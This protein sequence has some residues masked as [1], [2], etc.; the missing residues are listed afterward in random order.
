MPAERFAIAQVTP[1][2]WESGHQVNVQ[3]ARS[4]ELLAERGHGV[5]IVAPSLSEELVRRSR[6]RIRAGDA[7]AEPGAVEVLAVGEVLPAP[8][9]ARRRA[10]LPI[11]VARSVE[12][13]VGGSSFDICHLHEPFAPSVASV[14]LRHSRALNVGTFHAPTERVVATQV[15]RRLT[16]LVLGRLDVRLASFAVISGSTGE[17]RTAMWATLSAK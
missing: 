8:I 10:A 11:D 5:T 12:E 6:G 16:D 9:T 7:A 1:F 15:A 13:L 14:A 3:V 4:A 17:M 2:P